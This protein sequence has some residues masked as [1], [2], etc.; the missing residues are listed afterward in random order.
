MNQEFRKFPFG[1]PGL[2]FFLRKDYCLFLNAQGD[3]QCCRHYS[4]MQIESFSHGVV[5]D[6]VPEIGGF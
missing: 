2:C 5:G 6:Q 1:K 4:Q 3:S